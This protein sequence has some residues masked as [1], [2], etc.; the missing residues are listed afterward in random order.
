MDAI[1]VLQL[2]IGECPALVGRDNKRQ[3]EFCSD[4]FMPACGSY[5]KKNGD[6]K[7]K[8]YRNLCSLK[9]KEGKFKH[10]GQCPE[11]PKTSK[12]PESCSECKDLPA[13]PICGDDGRNYRNDCAC[14]CQ[15]TCSRYSLGSCPVEDPR[16]CHRNCP[17]VL[18]PQ[19]G[20]DG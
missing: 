10:F 8:T 7:M 1:G 13:K 14:E 15:G 16:H 19:C 6:E 3:C 9:C 12:I 18:D 5:K 2:G 11:K 17:G 20:S 4:V